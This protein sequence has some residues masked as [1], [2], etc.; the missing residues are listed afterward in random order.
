M[1]NGFLATSSTSHTIL[2]SFQ[3]EYDRKNRN[4]ENDFELFNSGDEVGSVKIR[5][6]SFNEYVITSASSGASEWKIRTDNI[7]NLKNDENALFVFES[8][9]NQQKQ[10]SSEPA[11]IICCNSNAD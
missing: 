8:A 3:S 9:E 10:K 11:E 6:I 7:K 4:P 1:R 5:S 2:A